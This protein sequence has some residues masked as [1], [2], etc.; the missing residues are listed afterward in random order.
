MTT[1]V[2]TLH[3]YPATSTATGIRQTT[4]AH[5]ARAADIQ[6][7]FELSF[8]WAKAP[9]YLLGYDDP[10][11]SGVTWASRAVICMRNGVALLCVLRS[12]RH[13]GVG[14][15]LQ[16]DFGL[17]LQGPVPSCPHRVGMADQRRGCKQEF[18]RRSGEISMMSLAAIRHVSGQIV[19]KLHTWAGVRM[20]NGIA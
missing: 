20:S 2:Q 12:C 18:E 3:T 4:A 14:C 19:E 13:A 5:M 7:A 1:L 10:R 6:H 11:A 16:R 17:S 8:A 15:C 9:K